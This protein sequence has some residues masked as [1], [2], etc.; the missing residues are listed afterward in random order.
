MMYVAHDTFTRDLQ[1]M[2]AGAGTG[3]T[4]EPVV[5]T[6]WAMPKKQPHVRVGPVAGGH[7]QRNAQPAAGG[8]GGGCQRPATARPPAGR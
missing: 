5:R 8:P 7:I 1:H 6:G 2:T 4:A 3:Q